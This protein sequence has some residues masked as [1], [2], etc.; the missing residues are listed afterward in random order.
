MLLL[1]DAHDRLWWPVARARVDD[2]RP[3]HGPSHGEGDRRDPERDG[4][5]AVAVEAREPLDGTG[6]PDALHGPALPFLEHQDVATGARQLAG[7]EGTACS[8]PDDDDV[9]G[10]VLGQ[11][12]GVAEGESRIVAGGCV[13]VRDGV[14]LG[15]VGDTGLREQQQGLQ[16]VEQSGTA[17]A[18][19]LHGRQ[20]ARTLVRCEAVQGSAVAGE[21]GERQGRAGRRDATA[22]VGGLGGEQRTRRGRDGRRRWPAQLARDQGAGQRGDGAVLQVGGVSHRRSACP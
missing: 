6:R 3:A 12:G 9:G 19:S 17:R 10:D 7:G 21:G 20:Q 13:A 8:R 4:R 11:F 16:P 5:A 1:P 15:S 2:G 14:D 22:D 18:S